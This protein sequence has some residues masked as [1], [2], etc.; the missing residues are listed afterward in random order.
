MCILKEL[1]IQE[2]QSKAKQSK[3]KLK[4]KTSKLQGKG[5]KKVV[6]KLRFL[7]NACIVIFG[8]ITECA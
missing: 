8:R 5:Q 2:K 1:S 3:R 7:S 6:I 4:K